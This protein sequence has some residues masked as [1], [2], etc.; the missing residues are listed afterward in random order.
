MLRDTFSVPVVG[1][2]KTPSTQRGQPFASP[3]P[4]R[5]SW[6]LPPSAPCRQPRNPKMSVALAME[7]SLGVRK[8]EMF[9]G[10]DVCFWV[11]DGFDVFLKVLMFVFGFLM[12]LMFF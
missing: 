8:A 6:N 5:F 3:G 11:F 1:G 2:K 10:F 7:V 9:K 4:W 12:V